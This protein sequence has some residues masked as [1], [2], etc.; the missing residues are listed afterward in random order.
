MFFPQGSAIGG[1]F[2][3]G[4]NPDRVLE[5]VRVVKDTRDVRLEETPPPRFYW[6]YAFGGAQVVLRGKVPASLVSDVPPLG[7]G[8]PTGE[9]G[10]KAPR[11]ACP[12]SPL[13]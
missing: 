2:T 12:K 3:V 6:H 4:S 11:T 5:V 10:C 1:Q 9:K 7:R 13:K 8:N